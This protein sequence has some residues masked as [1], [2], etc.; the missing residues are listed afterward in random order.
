[1]AVLKVSRRVGVVIGLVVVN[2]YAYVTSVEYDPEPA[3]VP[4]AIAATSSCSFP[5]RP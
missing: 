3:Q 4:R 5:T 1:M 2:S